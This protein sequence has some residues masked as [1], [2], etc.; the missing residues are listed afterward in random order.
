MGDSE[1][2]ASTP[3]PRPPE[4]SWPPTLPETNGESVMR[5]RRL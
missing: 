3:S 2:T 4:Q 5:V 1:V